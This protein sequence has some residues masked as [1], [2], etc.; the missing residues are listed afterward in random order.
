MKNAITSIQS[1]TLAI[2]RWKTTRPKP[3]SNIQ[4]AIVWE[5]Q[6]VAKEIFRETQSALLSARFAGNLKKRDGES[7]PKMRHLAGLY[8]SK[9]RGWKIS[10]TGPRPGTWKVP[11][12]WGSVSCIS[13]GFPALSVK[14]ADLL[15][16]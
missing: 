5:M 16:S 12:H 4:A 15:R 14:L 7:P 6:L 8:D 1:A 13:S 10:R 11:C 9:T 2:A 3:G